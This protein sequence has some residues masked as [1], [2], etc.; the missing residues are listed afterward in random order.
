MQTV[1]KACF[2]GK[3]KDNRKDKQGYRRNL[4]LPAPISTTNNK[5]SPTPGQLHIIPHPEVLFTLVSVIPYMMP[6][7]QQNIQN[8]LKGKGKHSPE[9]ASKASER[10]SGMMQG[11]E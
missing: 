4:K 10:A 1:P 8:T 3:P 6:G 9:K 2:L 11:L 5:Q 7:F